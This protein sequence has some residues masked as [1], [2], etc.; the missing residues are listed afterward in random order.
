MRGK[1]VH[2]GGRRGSDKPDRRYGTEIVDFS[3]VF[4]VYPEKLQDDRAPVK[5]VTLDLSHL[6]PLPPLAPGEKYWLEI[7]VTPEPGREIFLPLSPYGGDGLTPNEEASYMFFEESDLIPIQDPASGRLYTLP[8]VLHGSGADTSCFADC[9]GD[10]ALTF[11]DFLCFQ[12][13]FASG[14]PAADCDG[15]GDLSFFDFLCF[16]NAFAAGCP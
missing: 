12:D 9:D 4:C 11:F 8:V 16:Q 7:A 15:D 6:P 10:G 5:E 13:A 2:S 1:R 14:S 3:D